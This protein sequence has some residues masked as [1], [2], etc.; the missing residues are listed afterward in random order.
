MRF[1][2][3]KT[4]DPDDDPDDDIRGDI[5]AAFALTLLGCNACG[6]YGRRPHGNRADLSTPS[7]HHRPRCLAT[8]R[9][10]HTEE[11]AVGRF[12]A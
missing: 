8:H 10:R 12:A 4:R 1:W 5:R 6:S 11:G 9:T 7:D 3:D 2:A